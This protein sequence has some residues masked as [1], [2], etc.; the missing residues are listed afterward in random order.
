MPSLATGALFV[1]LLSLSPSKAYHAHWIGKMAN[2]SINFGAPPTKSE[3]D[4]K[5]EP[6][7][8][9]EDGIILIPRPSDDRN[10]P[11]V[12]SLAAPSNTRPL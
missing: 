8:V 1:K 6:V 12:R 5:E 3:F 4:I 9:S 7:K 10:D 11:L 2:Q